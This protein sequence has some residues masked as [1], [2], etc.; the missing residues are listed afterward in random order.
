MGASEENLVEWTINEMNEMFGADF[1]KYNPVVFFHDPYKDV[2]DVFMK[3]YGFKAEGSS[4]DSMGEA[5]CY[6][7][8]GENKEHISKSLGGLRCGPC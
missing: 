8:V 5:F 2:R 3:E 7:F 1:N 4:E 6:L